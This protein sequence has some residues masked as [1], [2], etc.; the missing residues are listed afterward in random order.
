MPQDETPPTERELAGRS[1]LVTGAGRGIGRAIALEL[2][3]RGALVVVVSRSA[4]ELAQTRALVEA[5]GGSA[6]ELAADIDVADWT[7]E[8]DRHAPPIDILVNNAAAFAPYGPLESVVWDDIERVLRT[9]L[10]SAT[11]LSRHVV[12]GMKE[13]GFGRLIQVG[14][15]AAELGGAGQVAYSSAKAGLRGLARTLAVET[16]RRGVTSNLLE[17]GLVDTERTHAAIPAEIR[18]ALVRSTPVGRPGTPQE[19]AHAVAFLASP[20][21]AFITGA[22]LQVCG[23]LGL[24]L[25]PEQLG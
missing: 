9:T 21:A 22:T 20:H 17:L 10:L 6:L 5:A 13:R 16:G 14:S 2:A 1:A 15:M 4:P 11:R 8:L 19:V 18:A 12:G 7:A 24:G 25:F 23:G 3:R